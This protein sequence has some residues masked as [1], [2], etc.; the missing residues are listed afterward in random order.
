[1]KYLHYFETAQDFSTAYSQEG[2]YAKSIVTPLGTFENPVRNGAVYY[3]LNPDTGSTVRELGTYSEIPNIGI[4][5][6]A[7]SGMPASP[8]DFL[9][10][11]DPEKA[12]EWR[13]QGDPPEG[14]FVE[15]T[16]LN[17]GDVHYS[18]PWVSYTPDSGIVAYNKSIWLDL[19]GY[20]YPTGNNPNISLGTVPAP[21]VTSS[22][23]T[24]LVREPDGK[25]HQYDC[26]EIDEFG[27]AFRRWLNEGLRSYKILYYS[28]DSTATW[29]YDSGLI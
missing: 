27:A 8:N 5:D 18:E 15:I 20:E 4:W 9:G 17:M 25:T 16:S 13:G 22:S 19:S 7:A 29:E 28:P 2:D 6:Y 24:I 14:T 12:D 21:P 1:M 26:V 3:W 23:Q 11:I 10:A